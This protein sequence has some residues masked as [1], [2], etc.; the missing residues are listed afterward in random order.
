MA[1]I[2]RLIFRWNLY[3]KS[4]IKVLVNFSKREIIAMIHSINDWWPR[5]Q[6]QGF[7]V[8]VFDLK[9]Q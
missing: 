3:I 2:K 5:S 4:I 8:L 9:L 1:A 7:A 6:Q